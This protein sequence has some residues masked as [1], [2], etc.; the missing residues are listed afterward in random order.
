LR[1]PELTALQFSTWASIGIAEAASTQVRSRL[2]NSP[3]A[4]RL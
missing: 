3:M 1:E 4:L 2:V